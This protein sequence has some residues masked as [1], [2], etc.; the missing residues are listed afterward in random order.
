MPKRLWSG[1]AMLALGAT[2]VATAEAMPSGAAKQGGVFR[3]AIAGASV[4]IDPQVSYVTT[5][6]WLEYATAAKL[7]NYPDKRGQAG[8]LFR[9]EVASG[10]RISRDGKTYTFTIRKGF[11]FSDGS[12][13]T[14]RNFVYAFERARNA[15]LQSPAAEFT[16]DVAGVSARG[17]KFVIHLMKPDGGFLAKLTM[18]LFQATSTKVPLTKEVS[19]VNGIADLPTAG[20][21]AFALNR[22]NQQ[23]RLVRNPYWKPGPGRRRPRNLTGL[24]IMWNAD[25]QAAYLQTLNN[26]YDEGPLPAAN[27][28]EVAQRFGVNR[29][30]FWTEPSACLGYVALNNAEGIFARNPA[31]RKAVNW[32]LDRTDYTAL[33]GPYAGQPWTHILPPGVPGS[34]TVKT[35][36]PYSARSNIA[37][38]RKLAAGHFRT[39]KVVVAYP[40]GGDTRPLQAGLVRRDLI[41]LGFKAENI[42]T[43][44]FGAGVGGLPARWD[45]LSGVGGCGS[46]SDPGDFLQSLPY[47]GSVEYQKQ[48]AAAAKLY[49]NARLRAFG[50]LDLAMMRNSAPVAPMR[51]YNNRFLFSDRVD[52][53]SLVFQPVYA[54]WSIP[55]LALK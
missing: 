33:A 55:A 35:R 5:G 31:L 2:L 11:R 19:G 10:Y 44:A 45:L 43:V 17:D 6:W 30:R 26:Q 51:T 37:K 50:R 24:S 14:A 1:L 36:Q 7:L 8:G 18:P 38:A 48:I 15:E 4:A 53:Q 21:Y 49:G 54:D 41:R 28:E 22:V 20:P 25:Q 40:A 16:G 39:G 42:T 23:T 27:V 46:D 9:L 34:V 47:F 29:T 12:P 52:P 3:V 13:V 32:A